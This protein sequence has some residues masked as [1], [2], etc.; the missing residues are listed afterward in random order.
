MNRRVGR[1][2]DVLSEAQLVAGR[3]NARRV[4]PEALVAQAG[5]R[6]I[7]QLL[8]TIQHV[9]EVA[10]GERSFLHVGASGARKG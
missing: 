9:A 10:T 6:P 2:F 5:P 7:A 3:T 8:D 4:A 1:S